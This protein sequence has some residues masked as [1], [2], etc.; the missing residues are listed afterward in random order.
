[1][2]LL[3]RHLLAWRPGAYLRASFGLLGWLL[4][5]AAAQA[6]MV[7]L[8]TR[9][10]G[11]DGYGQFVAILAVAG[12]FSPLAGLGLASVLLRDGARFPEQIP[13]LLGDALA[14]WWR[15]TVVFSLVAIGVTL[16]LLPTGI[17]ATAVSIFAVS[18]VTSGSLSELIARVEQ[19]RHRPQCFGA[20]LSGLILIRF[21][22]LAGYA[23]LAIPKING[24]LW[25]YAGSSGL[26]A[27]AL[28]VW[29]RARWRPRRSKMLATRLVREGWPFT[30]G[31]LSLRL[32]A[33]F[34]KPVLAQLGYAQA[35]HFS[36]AQRV[37]DLVSLPLQA[38]QEALWSKLYAS[39]LPARR[40]WL[41]GGVLIA[42][43]LLSG[44]MLAWLAHWITRIFGEGFE[45]TAEILQILA[46]LPAVQV[47]RN[48]GSVAVVTL[49]QHHVLTPIYIASGIT[50]V[51]L[52]S[53]LVPHLGLSGAFWSVYLS[54]VVALV[55]LYFYYNKSIP[56]DF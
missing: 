7:L 22:A 28:L 56:H 19:A 41:N 50:S 34:N 13:E 30:V 23:T 10:L 35:G 15:G 52:N 31:S 43:A 42:L 20:I 11:A 38:L 2:I 48:L 39:P 26:Y 47:M 54:E 51:I 40:L 29:I 1:M 14:L 17:Q 18:E 6:A 8:L 4:T 9:S 37:V 16:W 27:L 55:M 44:G 33:E 36:A 32:Q 25:I 46:W 45:G 21:I 3:A 53:L 12:F 49:N 24:W 5:R